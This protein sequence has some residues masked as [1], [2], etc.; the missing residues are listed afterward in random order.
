[1]IIIMH[2]PL[3]NAVGELCNRF[4][5]K[6]CVF[7]LCHS[8]GTNLCDLRKLTRILSTAYK[9]PVNAHSSYC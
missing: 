6:R 8:V 3:S 4:A 2:L 5:T 1:M 9:V 7:A